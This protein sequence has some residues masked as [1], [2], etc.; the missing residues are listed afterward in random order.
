MFENMI[1]NLK[2]KKQKLVFTEGLDPRILEA[3]SRL[4]KDNI[5][6]PLLLGNPKDVQMAA[7]KI[8]FLH[9]WN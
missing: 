1:E 8:W 3:A 6:E 5:L 9:R 7:E 4:K 2:A